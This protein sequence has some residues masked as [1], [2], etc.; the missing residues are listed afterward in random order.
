MKIIL[1]LSLVLLCL[2]T[3]LVGAHDRSESFSESESESES[4]NVFSF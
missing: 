1:H 2:S 3:N 4:E